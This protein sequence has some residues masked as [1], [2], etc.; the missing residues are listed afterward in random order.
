M[1]SDA[2]S[3]RREQ[4]RRKTQR[5][6]LLSLTLHAIATAIMGIGYIRWYH[7]RVPSEPLVSEA[8]AVTDL[9]RF[10]ISSMRK[11]AMPT[12]RPTPF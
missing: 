2:Y 11:R 9:Q 1:L 7:P 3:Y 5:A 10:H 12:R 4:K 8:I 6:F